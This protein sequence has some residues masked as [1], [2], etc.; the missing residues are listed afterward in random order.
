MRNKIL[1]TILLLGNIIN[2]YCQI[3]TEPSFLNFSNDIDFKVSKI[4]TE[5]TN[6]GKID[7]ILFFDEFNKHRKTITFHKNGGIESDFNLKNGEAD[8]LALSWYD[9]G[10]IKN[11][12]LYAKYGAIDI[13]YFKNGRIKY[14]IKHKS[15]ND[16]LN[17]NGYEAHWCENGQLIKECFYDSVEFTSLEYYCNGNKRSEGKILG[18]NNEIG[19]TKYWFE[20]GK[21]ESEGTYICDK[22]IA[23][24][25]FHHEQ[26]KKDGIWKYYNEEGKLAKTEK[27]KVGYLIETI[28]F[29]K[30][31]PFN[32]SKH[33][34]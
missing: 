23:I 4:D 32:Y 16:V 33:K 1:V 27:W 13:S 12:T 15:G 8:G 22:K 30:N 14:Y 11:T 24:D 28:D 10:E 19:Y 20:N 34:K 9:T 7:R 21:L 17:Y 25:I 5:Y 2:L 18:Y 3:K 26:S 29:V 31:P 6:N